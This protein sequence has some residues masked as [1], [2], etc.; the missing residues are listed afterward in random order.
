[1]TQDGPAIEIVIRDDW[2]KTVRL[3]VPRVLVESLSGEKRLSPRNLL[4]KLD[5]L[6]PGDVVV[7]RDRDDQVTIT[8]VPR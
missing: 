2:D 1:M 3:R 7:I 6:G 8:A 4:K 5:E